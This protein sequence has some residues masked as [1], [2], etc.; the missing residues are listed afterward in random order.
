[1]EEDQIETNPDYSTFWCQ[2]IPA[3]QSVM[4]DAPVSTNV[5]ITNA[6][7]PDVTSETEKKAVRLVAKVQT[8]VD[9]GEE[10]EEEKKEEKEG[11]K[12]D[13][14]EQEDFA[15][16][17]TDVLI[18]TLVPFEKENQELNVLFTPMN[19]VEFQNKGNLDIHLSGIITTLVP[20]EEEEDNE[21]EEE[22][23]EKA[24]TE[25]KEEEAKEEEKKEEE[26][27]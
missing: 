13:D 1:M 6:V 3:G 12:T 14:K 22:E 23:E 11:E 9:D 18:C 20:E 5:T 15:Y 19:I 2:V 24:E 17:S 7:I 25:K 8:L 10:E 21:E 27:K 16:T 4:L 26:T